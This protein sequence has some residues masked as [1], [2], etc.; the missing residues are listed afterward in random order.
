MLWL[1][2]MTIYV[3]THEVFFPLDNIQWEFM[4]LWSVWAIY[5]GIM[6]GSRR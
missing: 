5:D 3:V 4:A 6:R 1:A 2:L